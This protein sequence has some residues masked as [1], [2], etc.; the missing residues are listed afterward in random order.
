MDKLPKGSMIRFNGRRNSI[1]C[2]TVR[3][4]R[5]LKRDMYCVCRKCITV[6]CNVTASLISLIVSCCM[7]MPRRYPYNV[8]R[9][10]NLKSIRLKEKKKT[11]HGIRSCDTNR[12]CNFLHLNIAR[13]EWSKERLGKSQGRPLR[14]WPGRP[15]AREIAPLS[16]KP[17]HP[18]W[19]WVAFRYITTRTHTTSWK[20][21]HR[22]T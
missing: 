16:L 9:A 17:T 8:A 12:K 11:W 3:E 20:L 7:T 5:A 2:V 13:L 21:F 15:S 14:P 10:L 22:V 6:S 4:R 1:Q 18:H 19:P